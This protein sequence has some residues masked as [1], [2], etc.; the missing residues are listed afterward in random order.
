MGQY[1]ILI[2]TDE[3]SMAAMGEQ[4]VGALMAAHQRFGGTHGAALRGG[5]WLHPTATATTVRR[6]DGRERDD[7]AAGEDALV[8]DGPYVETKEALGGYYVVEAPD[9]DTALAIARQVPEPFGGV[10]VRPLRPAM[11]DLQGS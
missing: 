6:P 10:E 7:L 8:T 2:Y 3:A 11:Q 5:G 9:L 1:L 4:E